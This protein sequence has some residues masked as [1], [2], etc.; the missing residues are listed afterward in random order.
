VDEKKKKAALSLK[1]DRDRSVKDICE[2]V[3]ISRNTYY[4]Y[5]RS[6]E[7]PQIMI[8]PALEK[9]MSDTELKDSLHN[10]QLSE[11]QS[12]VMRVQLWLR[13]E[14]NSKFVRGKSKARAEIERD[15][16]SQFGMEKPD[17]AGSD[18][19]LSIP[20]TTDEE[21]NQ[22]IDEIY[23]EAERIADY[24]NCFTEGDMI[25]LDDPEKCW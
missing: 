11:S 15:V 8:N 17:K 10:S 14:N 6:E 20:Y 7:K 25:S 13:V 22:I 24:R 12:K 21:L 16:L 4:K 9:K 5:T 3:G 19:I 23:A 18:Y 2:I 1:K